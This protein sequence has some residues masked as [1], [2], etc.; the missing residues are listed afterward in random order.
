[1]FLNCMFS[2]VRLLLFGQPD[3]THGIS[4]GLEN[5]HWSIAAIRLASALRSSGG[6]PNAAIQASDL[7][8]QA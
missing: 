5:Q 4:Y 2:Y 1:V 8:H 3:N 7:V 6:A